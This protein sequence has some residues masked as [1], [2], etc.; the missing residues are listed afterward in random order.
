MSTQLDSHPV[1][2]DLTLPPPPRS[3]KHTLR[4]K[5]GN[6]VQNILPRNQHL[7]RDL[8]KAKLKVI[9]TADV[10]SSILNLGNN[11]VLDAPPPEVHKGEKD[12]PR[13]TRSTLSQL[14][15]GYSISLNSYKAR[16][17][18]EV[19][20]I[21]PN[22]NVGPHT[23]HHLFNCTAKPTNLTVRALWNKP[24]DVATFLGLPHEEPFDDH[25]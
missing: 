14:R 10:R 8:Y 7:D 20:D 3:M 6:H 22:C 2:V 24:L 18:P 9:H 4:S 19:D 23:T 11:P 12:L 15:S 5:F 1:R 17:E 16:L 21:C 25:G 13:T